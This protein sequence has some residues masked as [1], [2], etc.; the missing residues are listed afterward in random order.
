MPRLSSYASG[1][2]S[3]ALMILASVGMAQD[4][5]R[6]VRNGVEL[7]E[8]PY[9]TVRADSI[10][11][12]TTIMVCWENPTHADNNMRAMVREAVEETWSRHSRLQ[13]TG[14]ESCND[15][16][17]GIR[18][19]IDD[20]PPH[21]KALGSYL[22]ERPSGMVLN[23]SHSHKNWSPFCQKN[24]VFCTKA[25][26]VHEFGH[27]IGFAHEQ[28]RADVPAEC[29]SDAQGPDG[30]WNITSYDP[31]SIMNYCNKKWLGDGKLSQRDI[32][33]VI[34]MYGAR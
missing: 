1:L 20:G 2:L 12:N 7:Y 29:R 18:I 24:I 14:W 10:W 25:I 17:K 9:G 13:F 26:A 11:K 5:N 30:D 28:N 33:A 34:K 8:L 4:R 15:Q 3:I 19:R 22:D 31:H 16:S 21:V 32:D 6:I 27:A 23:S